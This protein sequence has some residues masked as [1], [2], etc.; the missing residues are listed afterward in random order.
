MLIATAVGP[1]KNLRS[2]KNKQLIAPFYL[3]FLAE[4]TFKVILLRMRLV[5]NLKALQDISL[6]CLVCHWSNG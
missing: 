5:N 2:L 3:M 1:S 4:A 6:K